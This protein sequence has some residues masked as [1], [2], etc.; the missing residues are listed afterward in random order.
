LILAAFWV[1]FFTETKTTPA[2]SIEQL[3]PLDSTRLEASLEPKKNCSRC[4][5]ELASWKK[6]RE[7]INDSKSNRITHHL[8]LMS[9]HY[10]IIFLP[11]FSLL[12]R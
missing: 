10:F 6:S 7:T 3:N 12:V 5:G 9:D 8:P 2:G 4:Q 11:F 1:L